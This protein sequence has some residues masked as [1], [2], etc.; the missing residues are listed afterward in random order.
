VLQGP[1]A[2]IE[3][4]KQIDWRDGTQS[5]EPV[6]QFDPIQNAFVAVP[7]DLGAATDQVFLIAYGT[8][9]RNRT[10][11]SAVRATILLAGSESDSV[12]AEVTFVA[13][14][15]TWSA[16]IKLTFCCRAIWSAAARA[17]SF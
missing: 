11:P 8:G 2:G 4:G 14:K 5:F 7:I 10:A 13:R 6:I 16:W 9:F 1:P 12:A 17:I 15:A 3:V